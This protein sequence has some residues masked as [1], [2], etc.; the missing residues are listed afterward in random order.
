MK[1]RKKYIN[2]ASILNQNIYIN[3]YSNYIIYNYLNNYNLKYFFYFVNSKKYYFKNK[4]NI[5]IVNKENLNLKLILLKSQLNFNKSNFYSNNY[6]NKF[7]ILNENKV[8]YLYLQNKIELNN[9]GEKNMYIS[10]DKKYIDINNNIALINLDI[11]YK[12]F[13][14]ILFL[15]N[16]L[17]IFEF[18][19]SFINILYLNSYCLNK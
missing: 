14:I 18:Y 5:Q 2:K 11:L 17:K 1:M 7:F 6:K 8:K 4:K 12:E 15:I 9:I 10:K 19:K 13:F 16:I 3:F